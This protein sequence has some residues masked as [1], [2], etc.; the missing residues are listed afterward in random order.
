MLY[1]RILELVNSWITILGVI[2]TAFAGVVVAD[3]FIV[4]RIT[5]A[6]PVVDVTMPS[7]LV[8]WAGVITTVGAVGTSHY[9]LSGI[10][11]IEFFPS[12]VITLVLYP[13]LRF[14]VFKPI[15]RAPDG[16]LPESVIA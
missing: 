13:L 10:M 2:T 4:R 5:G 6:G 3:Y 14:F 7:E 9:L 16:Q 15:S 12:L 1:G 11:P 8:N